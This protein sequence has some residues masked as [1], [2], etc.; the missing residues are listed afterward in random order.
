MNN[1]WPADCLQAINC[2]Y[3][4]SKMSSVLIKLDQTQSCMCVIIIAQ[5]EMGFQFCE[6]S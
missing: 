4:L 3:S 2:K 6:T 5:K 1:F